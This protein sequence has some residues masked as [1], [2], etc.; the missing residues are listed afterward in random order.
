MK[1]PV[2]I[3]I[4]ILSMTSFAQV[5]GKELSSTGRVNA[6]KPM[7]D[8]DYV[9]QDKSKVYLRM[10]NN[11]IWVLAVMSDQLYY[12][13]K[14]KVKLVNGKE[15]Y[16]MPNDK[17]ISLQYR[18]EKFAL[19]WEN[20]KVPKLAQPDSG[21]LNWIAADDFIIF[22]VPLEYLRKDL[23]VSVRFNYEW[24]MTKY[25]SFDTTPEHGI[26]FRGIDMPDAPAVCRENY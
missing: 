25:G 19:P 13:T 26:S 4:V 6:D 12:Y 8:L 2:L 21:S 14:K 9:C 16:A 24:E 7:V 3:L 5:N 17:A 1:V 20:V 15:F 22:S 10:N 18:V 23:Q 11:T